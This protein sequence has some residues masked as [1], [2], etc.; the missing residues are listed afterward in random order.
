MTKEAAI[1]AAASLAHAFPRTVAAR[2]GA[3]AATRARRMVR[4][5][6]TVRDAQAAREAGLGSEGVSS[7]HDA[8][9]G[10]VLGALDEMASASRKRFVV[11]PAEIPVSETAGSVCRC[12]GLDPLRTMGEG[13]LLLTCSPGEVGGL[14]RAM[15]RAGIPVKE[16]GVVAAGAGVLRST[17]G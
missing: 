8:T 12:F 5:C 17:P 9:D 16:I 6:T 13:A 11:D 3:G 2:A 4:L 15:S 14:R 1:E 10:G 7:M